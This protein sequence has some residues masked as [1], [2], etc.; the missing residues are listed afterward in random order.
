MSILPLSLSLH[1]STYVGKSIVLSCPSDI[2]WIVTD[3]S[4]TKRGLGATL[5][6]SRAGH[7]HLAGFYSRK[8]RKHEVTW[9]PC[10]VEALSITAAVKYFSPFIIQSLHPTT[11]LTDSKP[12]VR[13]GD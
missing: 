5:Y 13:S 8:L 4:V 2:L 12:C 1:R 7:L 3:G 9:P 10:E 11:V 6:V